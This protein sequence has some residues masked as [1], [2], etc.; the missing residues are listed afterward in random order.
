MKAIIQWN[1]VA[2]FVSKIL[3]NNILFMQGASKIIHTQMIII[4]SNFIRRILSHTWTKLS[5]LLVTSMAFIP[6]A[7]KYVESMNLP[8]P[9]KPTVK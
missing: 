7:I 1:E 2:K 3:S 4:T 6:G 9:Y 5:N 8:T